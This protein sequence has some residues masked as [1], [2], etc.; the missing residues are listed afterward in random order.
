MA[1]DAKSAG[2]GGCPFLAMPYPEQ[3]K[4]KQAY[5]KKHLSSFGKPRPILGMEDP[6]H[7]RN[8][9]ISTFAFAGGKLISGIYREGTHRVIP[10]D[11]CLLHA[12]GADDII[13]AV[14]EAAAFCR[15]RAYDEDRK[16][17]ILRHVL[18]RHGYHTGQYMVVMVTAGPLFPGHREFVERLLEKHPEITTVV[19]NINPRQN[20]AVMG[21]QERVL[22]GPGF[23]EDILCGLR[24]RISPRSFYQV[25]TVQTEVL[26]L[27]ALELAD[28]TGKESVIDAYCGIGTIGLIA[29]PHAGHVLGIEQNPDAVKDAILNARVNNI[30]NAHF[31]AGDAGKAMQAMAKSGQTADVVFMDPPRS[32][33]D[34]SFLNALCAFSPKRIVYISCNPET[35]ARDVH[36]LHDRGYKVKAI[37]PVDMFPHTEHVECVVE[38]CRKSDS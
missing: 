2:C 6:F 4:K 33:S 19:Q 29:A 13:Q 38:L 12:P 37:Q 18:V 17:G 1:C 9:V 22:Y 16:R 31:Q 35:Q 20:S 30:Q 8:K 32:G 25:N 14:R 28:L 27:K 3:L 10:V 7:Y 36:I 34:E 23:L 5:I 21:F 26:Y 11:T 15:L 24:F